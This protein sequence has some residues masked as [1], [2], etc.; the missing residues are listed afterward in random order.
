MSGGHLIYYVRREDVAVKQPKGVIH[1]EPGDGS[2]NLELI[3]LEKYKDKH[4][5]Y[6]NTPKRRYFFV[7]DG[8]AE[9]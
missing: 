8:T 3:N 9:R 4:S 5:F 1:L 2:Y 6:L 7:A